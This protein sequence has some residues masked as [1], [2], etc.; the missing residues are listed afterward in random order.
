MSTRAITSFFNAR[1]VQP[2]SYLFNDGDYQD[3]EGADGAK[4]GQKIWMQSLF[5]LATVTSRTVPQAGITNGW[6]VVDVGQ[7]GISVD[8][9]GIDPNTGQKVSKIRLLDASGTINHN[10]TCHNGGD[11]HFI[12]KGYKTAEEMPSVGTK[13]RLAPGHCDP[14]FNMHDFCVGVRGGHVEVVMPIARGPGF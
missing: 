7:K 1:K 8:S 5:L 12:L 4:A 10:I 14:T 6:V 9:D 13:I 3:I 11:E 2:G